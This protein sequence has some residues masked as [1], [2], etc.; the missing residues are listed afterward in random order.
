MN[1]EIILTGQT[2]PSRDIYP[3]SGTPPQGSETYFG[4]INAIRPLAFKCKVC[5][6]IFGEEK[7]YQIHKKVHGRK[8]KVSEY[9]SPEFSQDRL[10]G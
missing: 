2:S 3:A 1:F 9:G 8:P 10:R 6:L 4:Q 5:G 7:R